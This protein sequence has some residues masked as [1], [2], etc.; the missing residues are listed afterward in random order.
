M[1][2]TQQ[3]QDLTNAVKSAIT[4]RPEGRQTVAN[5]CKALY[6]LIESDVYNAGKEW[7]LTGM[8]NDLCAGNFA[9]PFMAEMKKD[10]FNT[11]VAIYNER[12]VPFI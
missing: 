12:V 1:T 9:E 10:T 3:I 5:S 8:Y 2:T 11:V 6:N 4:S 7:M